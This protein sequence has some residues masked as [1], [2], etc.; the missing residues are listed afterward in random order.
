MG[1]NFFTYLFQA[2]GLL[3]AIFGVLAVIAGI[4]SFFYY[5]KQT[6]ENIEETLEDIK[7]YMINGGDKE[8]E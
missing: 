2:I 7:Y 8:D 3:V 4:G 6:C 1:N 5:W